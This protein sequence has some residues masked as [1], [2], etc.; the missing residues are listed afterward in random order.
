MVDAR[1]PFLHG[2]AAPEFALGS[3][4]P[5]LDSPQQR[6]LHFSLSLYFSLHAPLLIIDTSQVI[7]YGAS[8]T[9]VTDKVWLYD[10]C[11]IVQSPLHWRPQSLHKEEMKLIKG[12]QP[13]YESQNMAIHLFSS[14][15]DA[16][17]IR[18]VHQLQSQCTRLEAR[19]VERHGIVWATCLNKQ[20]QSRAVGSERD[21]KAAVDN[22]RSQT[23]QLGIK[24][25]RQSNPSER[26]RSARLELV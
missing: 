22:L 21:F 11:P 3:S 13:D 17:S 23:P 24:E 4:A 9:R 1:L 8:D 12:P 20:I 7:E 15:I 25:K 16:T 5:L 14:Y 19:S 26:K 18:L 2:D 10:D 6:N